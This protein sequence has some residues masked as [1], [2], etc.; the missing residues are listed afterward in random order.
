LIAKAFLMV[1]SPFGSIFP[2]WVCYLSGKNSN[3]R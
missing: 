2:L 1:I 3:S